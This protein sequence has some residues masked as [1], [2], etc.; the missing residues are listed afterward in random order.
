MTTTTATAVGD[1]AEPSLAA[2][3]LSG[4]GGSGGE[5]AAAPPKALEAL[6]AVGSRVQC[7]GLTGAAGLN[8]CLGR[9]EGHEGARARVRMDGGRVVRVKPRNL[10]VVFEVLGRLLELFVFAGLDSPGSGPLPAPAAALAAPAAAAASPHRRKVRLWGGL[11]LFG[12]VE[13]YEDEV[14]DV[15]GL[16]GAVRYCPQVIQRNLNP[17]FFS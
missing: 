7:E 15:L 3:L 12:R 2:I 11:A 8:G 14:V 1:D 6:P 17:R 16:V 5:S 13:L 10:I 4:G 9:V